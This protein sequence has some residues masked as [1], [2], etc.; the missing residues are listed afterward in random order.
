MSQRLRALVLERACEGKYISYLR[1]VCRR[2]CKELPQATLVEVCCHADSNLAAENASVGGASLRIIEPTEEYPA[3]SV[4]GSL[5]VGRIVNWACDIATP[6]GIRD[7]TKYLVSL[8]PVAGT[9]I[10]HAHFSPCCRGTTRMRN[11]NKHRMKWATKRY[12][13]QLRGNIR[14]LRAVAQKYRRGTAPVSAHGHYPKY[15][16]A[17]SEQPAGASMHGLYPW[18]S[19]GN[20]RK[21]L[22]TTVGACMCGMQHDNEPV[23]K[24]Y[25]F[26]TTS[27][28]LTSLLGYV[29]C[30]CEEPVSVLRCGAPVS[31]TERYPIGLCCIIVAG[32]R[33]HAGHA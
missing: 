4:P 25:S 23:C 6:K 3:T 31:L 13:K 33:L 7:L 27:R 12:H 29:Q 20:S 14:N 8:Q 17:S 5:A 10:V 24:Q 18:I 22:Y 11:V 26:Q 1:R 28:Y 15:R 32:I 2:V 21:Y 19:M 16:T 9:G 30:A